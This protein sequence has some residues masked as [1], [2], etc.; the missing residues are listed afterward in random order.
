MSRRS[1]QGATDSGTRIDDAAIVREWH[2]E[3]G[4]GVIDSSRTP[5]GCWVLWTD[6]RESGLHS[7]RQ[8]QRVLLEWE[9]VAQDGYAFR[10]PG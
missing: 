4:W 6:F 7:L 9:P 8:G 5:G 3:D 2:T 1:C 10:P